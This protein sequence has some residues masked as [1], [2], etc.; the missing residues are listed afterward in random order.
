M[1]QKRDRT[2]TPHL[3]RKQRKPR[4]DNAGGRKPG[5]DWCEQRIKI[6]RT[7]NWTAHLRSDGRMYA[8]GLFDGDQGGL[9]GPLDYY[10]WLEWIRMVAS[11][12]APAGA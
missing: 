5:T 12:K 4:S 1:T 10:R 2:P 7:L 3:I 8:D 9:I 11:A 6:A